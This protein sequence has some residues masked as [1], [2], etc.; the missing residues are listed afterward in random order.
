MCECVR[1]H[2]SKSRNLNE[3]PVPTRLLLASFPLFFF[4]SCWPDAV[5]C[6]SATAAR[7]ARRIRDHAWCQAVTL[8]RPSFHSPVVA[9]IAALPR[10]LY[11]R[12]A[13][14]RLPT[15]PNDNNILSRRNRRRE[16][17]KAG[18]PYDNVSRGGEGLLMRQRNKQDV[19]G[20]PRTN[21]P[22]CV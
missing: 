22:M 21:N 14:L 4:V 11:C 18:C 19:A 17:R 8:S 2:L 6:H 9:S 20:P 1:S 13:E 16:E 10:Q 5:G 12:M 15:F 3:I 7:T